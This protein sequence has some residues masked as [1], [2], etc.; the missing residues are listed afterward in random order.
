MKPSAELLMDFTSIYR[1]GFAR[2][3]ACTTAISPADPLSNS[4]AI[5][6]AAQRCNERGVAI[7]TF[8]ELSLS[9][10]AID[11][12]L[13]Q[14]PVLDAVEAAVAHIVEVSATLLPVLVIGAP[15]RWGGRLYNCA[16]AIHRGRLLGV[17]PKVHLPN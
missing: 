9:G 5:L 17:V 15:V 11:D 10:Y 8:P 16:I 14:D 12:L 1:H 2:V 3:A 6:Q 13:L 4:H 7:A